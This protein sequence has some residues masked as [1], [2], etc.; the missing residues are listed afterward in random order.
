MRGPWFA[1]DPG[2][3]GFDW[4]RARRARRG[5]WFESGDMKYVILKL[6]AARSMHGYEVMKALEE[7]TRG[8]YKP[9]PGT[10]YPTLQWL[11]DEGLVTS[12]TV[13]GKKVYAITDAGRSFLETH[14]STVEDIFE[15]ITGTIDQLFSEPMPEVN[16]AI[17]KVVAQAYRAAWRLGKDDQKKRR[18]SEILERATKEIEAL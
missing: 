10:V 1:F 17:G 2:D 7:E 8:C 11:E 13:D 18:I 3:W 14:K 16:R 12:E 9:S 5:Q 15:R 4:R 6:L